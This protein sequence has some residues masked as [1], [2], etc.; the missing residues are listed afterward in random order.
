MEEETQT[1]P[2][3]DIDSFA[4]VEADTGNI[5]EKI[6]AWADGFFRLLPNIAVALVLLVLFWFLARGAAALVRRSG[7][8][9]GRDNLGDV[10]ASLLRWLVTILGIMLAVTIVAPSISPGDLFAGLGIGSVAIG[11]AFKDIL[12]NML[13]GILILIR[14]PF[15]V[16]DQI[17]S[18]GH[19]GTV[20]RIETRA[21]LIKTYDGRRVVIP[22]SDIYTDAVVV[23]TAFDKRRSQ[24]DVLIGCSDD[25]D[26]ACAIM[27]EA[28]SRCDGVLSDPAPEAIPWGM[29]A[30]GNT[31]RLRWWT[32]PARANVVHV[33]GRVIR[34]TYNALN[35][36][37]VDLPYPTRMVLFHD[38]TEATDGDRT[39]Q[40]EGWPAKGDSPE[41]RRIADAIR[42]AASQKP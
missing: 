40:R 26:G 19:E 30:D 27:V 24:Y 8:K 36:K 37:G 28:A 3:E 18:G 2:R 42:T 13:A 22:N 14:Q 29:D 11:F 33:W 17:V 41:P 39:A 34:D 21:T 12:Q 9:R 7:R 35:E 20:E 16:G 15:E 6:D 10:G 25:I 5:F 1:A 31:I 4:G 23:N 32:E 38:Q